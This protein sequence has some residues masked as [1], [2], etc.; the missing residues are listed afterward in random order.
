MATRQVVIPFTAASAVSFSSLAA[1]TNATAKTYREGASLDTFGLAGLIAAITDW[2][3]IHLDSAEAEVQFS[4]DSGANWA[5]HAAEQEGLAVSERT[6]NTD[7][8]LANGNLGF[9]LHADSID[10]D[11]PHDGTNRFRIY[12]TLEDGGVNRYVSIPVSLLAPVALTD[13]PATT[14]FSAQTFR[15]GAAETVID[16]VAGIAEI[17]ARSDLNLDSVTAIVQ[18]SDDSGATLDE[19]GCTWFSGATPKR[20]HA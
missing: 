1:T 18:Y 6:L 14:T 3:E 4:S 12:V 13:L 9:R 7:D 20:V 2:D 15:E 11:L 10:D 8:L 16:L 19:Y 5:E 17:T